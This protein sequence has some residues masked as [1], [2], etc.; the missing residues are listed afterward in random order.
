MPLNS[1]VLL[2]QLKAEYE[3]HM[4]DDLDLI[5][6]GAYY[7]KSAYS[8]LVRTHSVVSVARH[9]RALQQLDNRSSWVLRLCSFAQ[10]HAPYR[11]RRRHTA[12]MHIYPDLKLFGVYL[13]RS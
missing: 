2:L 5:I 7:S 10:T 9:Q 13:T 3:S 4:S 6:I 11:R 12:I 8:P 1:R